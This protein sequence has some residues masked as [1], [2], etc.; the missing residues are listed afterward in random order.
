MPVVLTVFPRDDSGNEDRRLRDLGRE[1]AAAAAGCLSDA[2]AQVV[3]NDVV[4]AF[5]QPMTNG[6]G[7]ED[8]GRR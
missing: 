4:G 5:E 1:P 2:L 8:R 6:K 7:I 3:A